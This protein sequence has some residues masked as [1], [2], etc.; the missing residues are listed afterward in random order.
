[1]RRAPVTGRTGVLGTALTK[2]LRVAGYTVR[3]M[4]R[5]SAPASLPPGSEWAQAD[6]ET[7]SELAD[8]VSGAALI[9]HAAPSPFQR[10]CQVNGEGT[11][12]QRH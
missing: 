12:R 5:C 2:R 3:I 8:A 10:S 9:V 11:Q 6:M 4:N 7:G 1:M